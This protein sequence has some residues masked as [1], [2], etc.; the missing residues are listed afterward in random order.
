MTFYLFIVLILIVLSIFFFHERSKAFHNSIEV[1]NELSR[2]QELKKMIG[3]QCST[4]VFGSRNTNYLFNRADLYI[5]DGAFLICGYYKLFNLKI[6][7]TVFVVSKNKIEHKK[8]F[9]KAEFPIVRTIHNYIDRDLLIKLSD[10]N[11]PSMTL[12]IRFK[13]LT[14]EQKELLNIFNH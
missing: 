8:L 5:F 12:E 13:G 7:K 3:T 1:I 10:E 4:L 11:F 6:F 14:K 2:T 9:P